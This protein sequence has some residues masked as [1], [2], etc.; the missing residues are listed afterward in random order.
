MNFTKTSLRSQIEHVTR[1]L[2]GSLLGGLVL[3]SL[4]AI[5]YLSNIALEE[6][7][8]SV[9]QAASRAYRDK[10]LSGDIRYSESQMRLAF[11][12]K[13]SESIVVLNDEYKAYYGGL[14]NHFKISKKEKTCAKKNVICRKSF[15]GN[16]VKSFPIY[17]DASET[18]LAGYIYVSLE[19]ELSIVLVVSVFLASL[20]LFSISYMIFKTWLIRP[21]EGLANS[22]ES[23]ARHIKDSPQST[24]NGDNFFT[25]F[26]PLEEAVKGLHVKIKELEKGAENRAKILI[27]R[28]IAHDIITP[29][30][31]MKKAIFRL[32]A[33]TTLDNQSQKSMESVDRALRR[34]SDLAKQVKILKE[35]DFVELDASL[36][37]K[38]SL[39]KELGKLIEDLKKEN[40]YPGEL[41]AI[42]L[43]NNSI[44]DVI[45]INPSDCSR[46][47]QNL[48]DNAIQATQEDG[49][50]SIEVV[51]DDKQ[52]AVI[53]KDNGCGM[54]ID[55]KD[56]MFDLD[57]TTKKSKGTG[58]GLSIVKLL[59]KKNQAKIYCQSELGKGTSFKVQFMADVKG[60]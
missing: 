8:D 30:S 17:H 48:L 59:C 16:A 33:L 18:Q 21:F 1:I 37:K 28:G 29:V 31:Q 34:I 41:P 51:T 42:S 25:E 52:P 4:I 56:K 13:K 40:D 49:N 12:L 20:L 54:S 38:V 50:V 39:E 2:L 35:E 5:Y 14:S 45:E 26:E 53:V 32:K 19:P 27:V 43:S 55:T 47:F 57:F 9:G 23:W 22:I 44:S 24:Y 60:A 6:K 46:I 15:W 58:L 7:V 11:N 3:L 36:K 10:I